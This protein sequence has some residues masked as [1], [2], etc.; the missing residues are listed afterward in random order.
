MTTRSVLKT[1]A[2]SVI[3]ICTLAVC[4]ALSAAEPVP[5]G[6]ED[7][8]AQSLADW[9]VPGLAIC[10]VRGDE[11]VLSRGFG[12][13]KLGE[14]APVDEH[15]LFA[16]GSCSKAF[17]AAAVGMLVDEK[18]LAWDDRV[19]QHLPAFELFDPYATRELTVRD[20]LCHR[21]GLERGDMVWYATAYD[22][23]EVMRRI[24]HLKPTWSFRSHYGYQNIMY[25][26]AGE[27]VAAVS[28]KSWDDF[29]KQR[30]FLPLGMKSSTT[31]TCDLAA[32]A[33]VANPHAKI[34]D[35]VEPIAWRNIDNVGPA[36][37]INSSVAEMAN[38]VR[39]QLAD[40]EFEGRRL[41][42]S[43]VIQETRMPQTLV[44]LEGRPKEFLP[45]AHFLAYGLG[46]SLHDY[47]D[48]KIVEHGGAIDGM[49]A[50]VALVP[51]EKLGLVILSNL[52]RTSLP[53]ALMFRVFDAYL[54]R[55][56]RDW[57]AEFLATTKKFEAEADEQEQKR[58]NERITD[59][60][61]SL[62]LADFAGT[63]RQ[64]L[65]GEITVTHEA[66]QLKF[67]FGPAFL[68]NMEHWH[69]DT[70]RVK[71]QDKLLDDWFVTFTLG[72]DGKAASLNLETLGEFKRVVEDESKTAE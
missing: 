70:F 72:T 8:I 10:V 45:D 49:R 64:D 3:S 39:M 2:A 67:Q 44:R 34:D 59:T 42:S 33:N 40:G 30:F 53:E 9:E 60:K 24:R 26:A 4:A 43:E 35:K 31:S 19:Q 18:K 13:R 15:T 11:V 5:E 21:V 66:D 6:L 36:G 28:G 68:G 17:T 55:D 7:Y 20:L 29:I 61:P 37:S 41:I 38:W 51:E 48:R 12:V 63:Y 57:S 16:I 22:R 32:G 25:L 62:A 50:K 27:V 56:G 46:W 52:Q 23:A 14:D 47:H 54:G 1:C 71:F 58:E 65:H 69:L